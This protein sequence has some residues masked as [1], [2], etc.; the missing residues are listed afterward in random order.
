MSNRMTLLTE[1]FSQLQKHMPNFALSKQCL[2]N[3]GANATAQRSHVN[4]A[5]ATAAHV[6]ADA[7][8]P[9]SQALQQ[10]KESQPESWHDT[11]GH[12]L[13]SKAYQ[14]LDQWPSAV[15]QMGCP[16]PCMQIDR[17]SAVR[18]HV[19]WHGFIWPI[20]KELSLN[21]DSHY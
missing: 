8:F 9:S 13:T 5:A 19:R 1:W 20:E 10:C 2:R 7:I 17:R 6:T 16:W 3:Q 18:W 14:V 4:A 21:L 15:K 12:G 11:Y